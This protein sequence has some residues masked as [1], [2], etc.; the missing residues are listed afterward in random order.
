MLL[1]L[2]VGCGKRQTVIYDQPEISPSGYWEK[3]WVEPKIVISDS[4]FTL[5]R[6]DFVDSFYVEEPPDLKQPVAP[7]LFMPVL[8]TDCFVVANLLDDRGEVVRPLIAQ[9]MRY[10]YYQLTIN[11]AA[12]D[13]TVTGGGMLYVK[14]NYC[15]FEVVEQV[16][17]R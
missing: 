5:I 16:V 3:A 15:G 2:G 1:L 8:Q 7:S 13:P 6:S 9:K 4:L 17:V 10:G 11:E 12:L 14:V